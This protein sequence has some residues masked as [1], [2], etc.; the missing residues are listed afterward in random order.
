MDWFLS[1]I[2]EGYEKAELSSLTAGRLP[3]RSE[4]VGGT[5]SSN[6]LCRLGPLPLGP[7]VPPETDPLLFLPTNRG[8]T[9]VVTVPL[10]KLLI[11]CR[12]VLAAL[13]RL[14]V[15]NAAGETIDPCGK[16]SE[17]ERRIEVESGCEE[18]EV[19]D[20]DDVRLG[21]CIVGSAAPVVRGEAKVGLDGSSSICDKPFP[22]SIPPSII[23]PVD[24]TPG[25]VLL[26]TTLGLLISEPSVDVEVEA[27][28][29][30]FIVDIL[31]SF[32]IAICSSTDFRIGRCNCNVPTPPVLTILI[33][34][35]T[36][37]DP[38]IESD[39]RRPG[40]SEDES[41]LGLSG[42]TGYSKGPS[43]VTGVPTTCSPGIGPEDPNLNVESEFEMDS[44]VLIGVTSGKDGRLGPAPVSNGSIGSEGWDNELRRI[45]PRN[46]CFG[47]DPEDLA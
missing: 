10:P 37:P 25:T 19:V 16:A 35:D 14:I 36:I 4:E 6:K 18:V 31:L 29:T 39:S 9:G 13:I 33:R 45:K 8:G 3:R 38:E 41:R 21:V 44:R 20:D 22:S 26:C 12:F 42:L 5:S 15:P 40:S 46:D 11:L 24:K 43:S 47:K 30:W 23:S 28:T 2:A 27:K 1:R 32:P 7:L 17:D 34:R